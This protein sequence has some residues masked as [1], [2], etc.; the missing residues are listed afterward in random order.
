MNNHNKYQLTTVKPLGMPHFGNS[1]GGEANTEHE[2]LKYPIHQ[3]GSPPGKQETEI[4]KSNIFFSKMYTILCLKD[5]IN[6]N[7]KMMF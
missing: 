7:E 1:A 4:Q 5:W 2:Y 6:L 3:H